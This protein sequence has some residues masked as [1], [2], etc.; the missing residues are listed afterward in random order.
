MTIYFVLFSRAPLLE[1]NLCPSDLLSIKRQEEDQFTFTDWEIILLHIIPPPPGCTSC[2]NDKEIPQVTSL[3]ANHFSLC[4]NLSCWVNQWD[5]FLLRVNCQH[6]CKLRRQV[7]SHWIDL[8]LSPWDYLEVQA[9]LSLTFPCPP[10]KLLASELPLNNAARCIYFFLI[11]LVIELLLPLV[12][13]SCD[14]GAHTQT[15]Y[16]QRRSS[17][18]PGWWTK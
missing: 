12:W 5:N 18:T 13:T 14:C 9:L 8:C 7:S 16:C 6:H 10:S 11:C 2:F 1:D 4:F 15:E 3:P 17:H